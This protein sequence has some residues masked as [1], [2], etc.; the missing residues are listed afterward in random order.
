M[1]RRFVD[2]L[3][4]AGI[5]TLGAKYMLLLFHLTFRY[6]DASS[7]GRIDMWSEGAQGIWCFFV[8]VFMLNQGINSA[9]SNSPNLIIA[10][11]IVK[12]SSRSLGTKVLFTI[13]ILLVLLG[14]FHLLIF[15]VELFPIE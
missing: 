10:T 9:L 14:V 11:C 12:G 5:V 6:S 13:S 7:Y 15:Y 4:I 8:G 3:M 1:W 2:I